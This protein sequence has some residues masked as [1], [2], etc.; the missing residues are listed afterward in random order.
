M[1]LLLPAALALPAL[2]VQAGVI[3]TSLHSFRASTNGANPYASLVQGRDGYFYG[4][5]AA[6]G[7]NGPN[8]TVFKISTHGVLTSLYSFTGGIDGANPY[9]ALVQGRD[10]YFYGTTSGGGGAYNAGTV[11][12]MS[13]TGELTNLHSFTGGSDGGHADAGLVEG[14]DG[15]FYGTTTEGGAES[16]GTVFKISTNGALTTLYVFGTVRNLATGYPADGAN[17]KAGLA[18]GRDGNFYGTTWGGGAYNAGTVFKISPTGGLT[19]L[20]SFTGESDGGY[21]EAGLVQGSDGYF[22][23]TTSQNGTDNSGTVFKIATNGVLTSLHSFNLNDGFSPYGDLVPGSDGNFY[24]TTYEGGAFQTGYRLGPGTV[25]KITPNGVLTSL[26]SFNGE[27][28]ANPYA[29]LV[30]GRDGNFYGT[31]SDVSVDG[32]TYGYGTVFK[33]S[34]N[35]VLTSLYSFT[36]DNN[37]PANPYA[38]LVQGRDGNFYGTTSDVSV[39]GSTY[40]YGTVFKISTNGALTFLHYFTGGNDGGTPYAGLVQGSDG[41]FYGTT[42][43]GGSNSGGTVFKISDSGLL[44]GLYSFAGGQDGAIPYAGLVQGSDGNFYGMTSGTDIGAGG[45]TVFQISPSG[46]LT[47]LYGFGL[48][49]NPKGGPPLDGALPFDGLVQGSD[50]YFYGMTDIGGGGGVGTVFKISTNGM[51]T[52]LHSFMG[53]NDGAYPFYAGLVQ[54]SDGNFY[55]TTWEGGLANQDNQ[56][57][58]VVFKMTAAGNLTILHYFTGGKDG[59]TPYGGL[60]QGSDGYLYGTTSDIYSAGDGTVFRISTNGALTTLHSFTGFDGATPYAG[61]VQG[62]DGRFYGTTVKGGQGGAGTVFRLTVVPAAPVFQAVTLANGALNLTW[63]TEAGGVYQLQSSSDLSSS[64]WTNL[65][66]AVTAAGARLSA[67]DSGSNG[68]RRFYRVVLSP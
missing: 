7:A 9:A 2:G 1:R 62:S 42:S 19:N 38:G 39:D 63:S 61:L 54:G 12:K 35:G 18:Q 64:N 27:D 56:S 15:C 34:T 5:T 51:L 58:G 33:I 4:T 59:G 25:F 65:G 23:G 37:G 47:T 13:A 44:I 60:V 26:H 30:Q 6:G 48:V 21:P 52:T 50:G 46:A 53:G 45:G 41:Y 11:F 17:P 43:S 8:G 40:G 67:T 57:L 55:G 10:G 29:G 49:P 68:P 36:G 32:S 24:G 22:Y 16:Y 20:H 28:G 3:L 31:T 14:G 66:S